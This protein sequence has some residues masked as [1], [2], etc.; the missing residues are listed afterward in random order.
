MD[1]G[2]PARTRT[3]AQRRG[4]QAED[5]ALALLRGHGLQPLARNVR[6]K[7]GELDLV[8]QDAGTLVFVEVRR[9]RHESW[10]GALAS[11][12]AAKVRRLARAARAFLQRHPCWAD[13]P[14]RFDVVA[15]DAGGAPHWL[16]HAFSLDGLDLA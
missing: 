9:R 2:I 7:V 1:R 12:D 13:A 8:M 10:G 6:F 3:E 15:F 4:D 14:C 11:I 5:Q 16:R